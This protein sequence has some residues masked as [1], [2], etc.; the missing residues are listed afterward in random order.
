MEEEKVK[1]KRDWV[2]LIAKIATPVI[3]GALGIMINFTIE[4]QAQ[5]NRNTQLYAEIMSQREQADCN[6][7]TETLK[8]LIENYLGKSTKNIQEK[9]PEEI[10]ERIGKK[11]IFLELIAWNFHDAFNIKPLFKDLNEDLDKLQIEKEKKE[12]L[13]GRLE[14][15][16]KE[17]VGKQV[18]LLSNVKGGKVFPDITLMEGDTEILEDKARKISVDLTEVKQNSIRLRVTIEGEE[19]GKKPYGPFGVSYYDMPFIDHTR[20]SDGKRLAITLENIFA[21]PI[22]AEMRARYLREIE[23]KEGDTL[24]VENDGNI[25]LKNEDAETTATT[26]AVIERGENFVSIV[27]GIEEK[28]QDITEENPLTILLPNETEF[29]ITVKDITPTKASMQACF[30]QQRQFEK[31]DKILV[32]KDGKLTFL[33]IFGEGPLELEGEESTTQIVVTLD[34][35]RENSVSV[36]IENEEDLVKKEIVKDSSLTIPLANEREL[37][38][39]LSKT[40]KQAKITA[41]LFPGEYASLRDKPYYEEMLSQLGKPLVRK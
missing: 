14:K 22:K 16:A 7:R 12:K 8:L 3:I 18:I 39:Y 9:N 41:L 40:I 37:E 31:D 32:D 23:V 10:L 24:F 6:L 4:R 26:I 33:T 21:R 2:G 38:L 36:I 13:K 35:I 5:K 20:L 29:A 1:N 34:S 28:M 19:G 15:I 25:K 11:L 17:V 27:V 30:S